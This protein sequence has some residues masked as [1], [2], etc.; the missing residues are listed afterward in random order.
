MLGMNILVKNVFGTPND[1][2]IK[3]VRPLITK[4]NN[5]EPEFQALSD[6]QIKAKTEEFKY[7]IK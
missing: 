7:R 4:I 2:K 5:L 3:A 1:R 6:D